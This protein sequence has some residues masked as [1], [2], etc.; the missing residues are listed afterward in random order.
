MNKKNIVVLLVVFFAV[1]SCTA[2]AFAGT[3]QLPKTD[4]TTCWDSNG[5]QILCSGRGQDGEFQKGVPWPNPRFFDNLDGTVTDELTGLMWTKNAN[6]AGNTMGWT[7]ALDYV[8]HM[9]LGT[10]GYTDWRVPNVNELESLINYQTADPWGWLSSQGFTNA[11]TGYYW[12]STNSPS[13]TLV[14]VMNGIITYAGGNNYAWPVRS[15]QCGVDTSVICLP[16]TGQTAIYYW[17]DDG[18]LQ[19]GVTWPN[20]RF[21]DNLD[22]TVTDEL[23]GLMWTKNADPLGYVSWKSSLLYAK[24][25]NTGGNTDWRIPNAKELRSLI[26]YSQY[27]PALPMGHPF[28]NV[29][30]GLSNPYWSSTTDPSTPINAWGA[31]MSNGSTNSV[32]KSSLYNSYDYYGRPTSGWHA[33]PVR[34]G[35]FTTTTTVPPTSTTTI[36]IADSDDDGIP[37]DEDNCPKIPNGP[38]LGTCSATSDKPGIICH[39][40]TD[41]VVGCS[42]NANAMCIND[43]GDANNDGV[44]DVCDTEYLWAA[45]QTCR[46]TCQTP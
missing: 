19:Q 10:Y 31:S 6:P 2:F 16:K 18:D 45:I 28:T 7:Q 43:Q 22:G 15:G 26:D 44:G 37:D 46:A 1:L 25:L 33:W 34:G 20:P 42:S 13:G 8:A 27:S 14:D 35:N 38:T 24:T 32:N 40:G 29:Q 41:C 3:I 9:N 11:Q 4:Q 36:T 30:V 5:N 23:T 21:V 39:V 17:D 12:S